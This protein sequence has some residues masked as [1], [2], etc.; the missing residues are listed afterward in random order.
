MS[1]RITPAEHL[2]EVQKSFD[3]SINPRLVEVMRV[4]VKHLHANSYCHHI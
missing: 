1:S 3:D 4:A 2:E